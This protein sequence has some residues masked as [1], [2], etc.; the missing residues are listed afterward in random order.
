MTND[1]S[2]ANLASEPSGPG[3]GE[4]HRDTMWQS[5]AETWG[6]MREAVS[7]KSI[8]LRDEDRSS[9]KVLSIF[10]FI[11]LAIICVAAYEQDW[12]WLRTRLGAG[13][14]T[15]F[16]PINLLVLGGVDILYFLPLC[17]F[18]GR[19]MGILR[20]MSKRHALICC[21][22]MI[23]ASMLTALLCVNIAAIIL[24][25]CLGNNVRVLVG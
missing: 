9:A 20:T 13:G 1:E 17:W 10:I 8:V 2:A 18:V 25:I 19:R 3:P 6:F 22:L 15:P 12:A 7:D 5:A 4:H 24:I 21:Q 11:G 14:F 16:R 23:G